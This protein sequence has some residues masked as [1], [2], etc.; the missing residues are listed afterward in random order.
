MPSFSHMAAKFFE[1]FA[2][3]M[4]VGP[5]SAADS[6]ALCP[7]EKIRLLNPLNNEKRKLPS[8]V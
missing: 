6:S 5:P 3:T 1:K 8:G 4:G 7:H 2:G